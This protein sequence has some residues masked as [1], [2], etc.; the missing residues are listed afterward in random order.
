MFCELGLESL[1]F[2][3]SFDVWDFLVMDW[4]DVGK[5]VGVL[6]IFFFWDL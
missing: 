4:G 2:L 6:V 5:E 3:K 1:N